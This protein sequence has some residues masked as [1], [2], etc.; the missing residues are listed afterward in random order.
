MTQSPQSL[1]SPTPTLDR[2][3]QHIGIWG[4]RTC[5]ELRS[6]IHCRNCSVYCQAGRSLLEREI[7]EEA[8]LAW[9]QA[10]AFNALQG[11]SASASPAISLMIFRLASEWFALSTAVFQEVTPSSPIRNIPHRTNH[12]LLGVVNVRGELQL[13]VSLAHL[14]GIPP[15]ATQLTGTAYHRFLVIERERDRWVFPVDEIFGI[16]H[17]PANVLTESPAAIAQATETYTKGV[18]NWS[19]RSISVLDEE[20]LCYRLNHKVLQ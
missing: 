15:I 2:C 7:S 1:S 10:E 17:V 4:D 13:C 11:E 5:A 6:E 12:L 9:N 18:L 3:W 14:L 8:L 16:H 20:L 19:D